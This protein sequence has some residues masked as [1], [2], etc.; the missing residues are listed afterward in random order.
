MT[1]LLLLFGTVMALLA[2]GPYPDWPQFRGVNGSGVYSGGPLPVTLSPG[3]SLAWSVNLPF[4]RSS[5]VVFRQRLFITASEGNRLI[6]LCFNRVDGKLLWRHEM[7]RT[8]VEERVD[9]LN[10]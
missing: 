4:G 9:R 5:P 1:M 3:Q 2:Q 10:D 6:T 7:T 8:R